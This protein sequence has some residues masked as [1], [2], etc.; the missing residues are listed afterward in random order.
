MGKKFI[1]KIFLMLQLGFMANIN[2]I[3]VYNID[4]SNIK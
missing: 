2:I 3:H 4:I 1:K